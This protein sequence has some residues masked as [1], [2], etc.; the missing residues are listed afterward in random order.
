M[1]TIYTNL[2]V[3]LTREQVTPRISMVQGDTGRGLQI[4]LTDDVYVE[5][6]G[7]ADEGLTAQLWAKKPSGKEVSLDASSVI[8]YENSDSYQ[9]QFDGSEAFAQVIAEPGITVVQVLLLSDGGYITSFDIHINVVR[10]NAIDSDFSS[11]T[12]YYSAI[13]ILGQLKA[14]QQTLDEYISQFS[15]QLKLTVNVRSGTSNP[16]VQSGDKQNDIYIKYQ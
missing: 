9:I 13:Q 1:A 6:T 16:T 8:R 2:T 10:N 12:E 15:D 3:S 7:E 4:T 5:G 14:M 11:S